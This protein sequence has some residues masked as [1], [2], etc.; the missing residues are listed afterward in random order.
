M[1]LCTPMNST[2]PCGSLN[3][4][5]LTSRVCPRSLFSSYFSLTSSPSF[6]NEHTLS[7]ALLCRSHLVFILPLI[8]PL[9]FMP[10]RHLCSQKA[11]NSSSASH[12]NFDLCF[13]IIA[14]CLCS[15]CEGL[16]FGFSRATECMS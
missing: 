9:S 13:C 1:L 10:H 16:L 4:S 2:Y 3:M 12:R 15:V 6:I 7:C 14:V 5:L 8:H 11:N